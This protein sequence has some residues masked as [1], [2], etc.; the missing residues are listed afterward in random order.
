[1]RIL[2]TNIGDTFL[3]SMLEE[4]HKEE[5]KK[6]EK[7]REEQELRARTP[8]IGFFDKTGSNFHKT[9]NNFN[10]SGNNFNKTG[11]LSNFNKTRNDFNKSHSNFGNSGFNSG[12]SS[13]TNLHQVPLQGKTAFIEI[14][15]NKLNLNRKNVEKYNQNDNEAGTLLPE[16][17]EGLIKKMDMLATERSAVG[18]PPIRNS[19]NEI[20]EL[21]PIGEVLKEQIGRAHV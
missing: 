16:L 14:K 17:P 1:M 18:T 2:V 5:L 13:V 6:M 21:L 8:S 10:K 12:T 15:T 4:N 7:L 3:K 9:G 19:S 11:S 20:I